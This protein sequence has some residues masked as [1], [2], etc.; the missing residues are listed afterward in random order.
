MTDQLDPRPLDD[1]EAEAF[2]VLDHAQ[3]L[4]L[5]GEL[6]AAEQWRLLVAAQVADWP[7]PEVLS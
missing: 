7:P 1:L 4:E 3:A 2:E 6:G 5:T